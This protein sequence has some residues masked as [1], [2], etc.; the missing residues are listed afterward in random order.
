MADIENI[1][2]TA[3][4]LL[5]FSLP[6]YQSLPEIELYMDQ[7]I[8]YL[9]KLLSRTCRSEDGEPL[10]PNR[11]NNYVKD[12]RIK[13]P[14]Q[15]KYDRDR[16]AM[17]YMLC[18]AKQNLSLP[19]ASALLGTLDKDSTERLYE[20]FKALQE[21]IVRSCAEELCNTD[22][23]ED[24]MLQKALELIVR[25]TAERYMAELVISSLCEKPVDFKKEVIKEA[26]IKIKQIKK[27]KKEK[28][29]GV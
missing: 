4:E 21:P 28:K 8:S 23:N 25:S 5:S 15:K 9:N 17:L 16:I 20:Q 10:T 29:D 3:E 18:C 24:A 7:L 19:D 26:T 27:S 14:V 13:R 22:K 2:K 1:G 12:G 6:S 11:V